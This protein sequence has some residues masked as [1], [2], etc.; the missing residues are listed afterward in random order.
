MIPI[1]VFV[2]SV[3]LVIAP[4]IDDPRME[5]LYVAIFILGGLIFYVPFVHY[6]LYPPCMSE[7]TQSYTHPTFRHLISVYLVHNCWYRLMS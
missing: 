3:F 1:I 6:K 7:Y 5:F 4:I 2:V